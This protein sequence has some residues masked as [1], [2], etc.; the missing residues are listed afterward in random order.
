MTRQNS[1]VDDVRTYT[2]T[3]KIADVTSIEWQI[4]LIDAI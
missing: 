3:R 1:G 2:R 4:T